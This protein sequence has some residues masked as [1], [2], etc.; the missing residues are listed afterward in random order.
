[1]FDAGLHQPLEVGGRV[2]V[3]RFVVRGAEQQFEVAVT[4]DQAALQVADAGLRGELAL[5]ALQDGPQ[6][7]LQVCQ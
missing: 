3:D 4:R 5:E 2:G 7:R 1:M 6:H